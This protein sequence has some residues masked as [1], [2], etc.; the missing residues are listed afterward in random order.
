MREDG[1]VEGLTPEQLREQYITNP[2]MYAGTWI[3]EPLLTEYTVKYDKNQ[4][5]GS[6]ADDTATVDEDYSILPNEF[7][8]FGHKFN[9]WNTES[10]GSGDSYTDTIPAN[11]YDGGSTVTLYAQ[12]Q[13]IEGLTNLGNGVYE[14]ELQDGMK[15]TIDDIPAGVTYRVF[16]ETP[17]GWKLV[18]KSGENGEIKPLET[19][20]AKFTN[21]YVPGTT[22]VQFNGVKHLDGESADGF[23]FELVE[24]GTAIQTVTSKNG[25]IQ[26]EQITYNTAGTHEYTIREVPGNDATINYDDHKVT[27]TVVVTDNGDGTLSKEVTYNPDEDIVFENETKEELLYGS[28]TIRKYGNVEDKD[29]TFKF[30][31]TLTHTNGRAYV[32]AVKYKINSNESTATPS[33]TGVVTVAGV[34]VGDVISF[35]KL[36]KD[37]KFVVNEVDIPDGWTLESISGETGGTISGNDEYSATFT[38]RYEAS[39]VV[40]LEAHKKFEGDTLADGQFTFELYDVDDVLLDQQANGALDMNS[41]F[42]NDNNESVD[43][44]WYKTGLVTFDPISYTLADVGKIFTYKIVE[45]QES[46]DGIIYDDH[47]ETVTVEVVDAGGGIINTIVTYDSEN[48]GALFVN[49]VETGNLELRKEISHFTETAKFTEFTFTITF[50][51]EKNNNLDSSY[52]YIKTSIEEVPIM[53]T[54]INDEGVEEEYDTGRTK[55]VEVESEGTI[56]SGDTEHIVIVGLPNGATYTIEEA[57]APGWTLSEADNVE[58]TIEAGETSEALFKNVYTTEGSVNFEASKR[59]IGRD[60]APDTYRFIIVDTN[61]EVV[62][63]A[64]ANTD[65]SVVFNGI[66]YTAQDDGK[67]F[68]Y[69]ISEELGDEEDISYDGSVKEVRVKVNDNGQG[70]L[71]C[72]VI[73]PDEGMEFINEVS[74]SLTVSKE[75]TGEKADPDRKFNFTLSLDG[76]GERSISYKKMEGN[77]QIGS[78]VIAADE[79][80]YKFTLNSKQTITFSKLPND[81]K[82]TLVEDNDDYYTAEESELSGTIAGEDL[83]ETFVNE[84]N[85]FDVEF[86]KVNEE[87]TMISGAKLAIYQDEELV[88]EWTTDGNTHKTKLLPGEYVLKEE[89]VSDDKVY[90]L[91]KD[92]PFTVNIDGTV[93]YNEELY[94]KAKVTM[95][96]EYTKID[97]SVV[98]EWDDHGNQDGIRPSKITI[99]LYGNG[100]LVETRVITKDD[101][102]RTVFK[103]LPKH[104]NEK[105]VT[106]TV[107]EIS[108]S[109][110]TCRIVGDQEKGFK[111]INKHT[112]ERPSIPKTGD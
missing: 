90:I 49:S 103:N 73:Y 86:D 81:V 98:K 66:D 51:D 78:G 1:T 101:N 89:K 100:E 87:G 45:K 35:E 5:S 10:D 62:D 20:L 75:V 63:Y 82:Y 92:I 71:V 85:W 7:S 21:R 33:S 67:I 46:A 2:Q 84:I 19:A 83:D 99:E 53:G 14:F 59:L 94:E 93:K 111:I 47:E 41:T 74:Y 13:P 54:R 107:K 50:K 52:E 27:V 30:N 104:K 102:W 12:W 60:I 16:E 106:Y 76:L 22:S 17:D 68:Y 37:V 88:E 91:A 11:T 43:N 57:D 95:V 64:Y 3:W 9:N 18:S 96:D 31:V 55:F 61:G 65:G 77:M 97:I 38:N 4:G 48:D 112:P 29:D 32:D 25:A 69:Y 56:K 23:K 44:P 6:M 79:L 28:L 70:E 110:Y 72:E 109:G 15:M 58:G 34:K 108:V 42:L 8:R 26:F 105:E 80:P 40:R 39:G 36:P 24:N